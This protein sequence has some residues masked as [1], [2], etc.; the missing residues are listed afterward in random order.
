MGYRSRIEPTLE[1]IRGIAECLYE[2]KYA[3]VDEGDSCYQFF[4]DIDNRRGI[5]IVSLDICQG[6]NRCDH[7]GEE[8]GVFSWFRDDVCIR[9]IETAVRKLLGGMRQSLMLPS[10]DPLTAKIMESV[11]RRMKS[12]AR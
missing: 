4:L 7:V 2:H 5:F 10:K 11:K 8:Q 9:N 12:L 6:W 1:D 3:Q